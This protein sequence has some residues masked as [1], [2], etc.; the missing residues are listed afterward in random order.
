[1]TWHCLDLWAISWINYMCVTVTLCIMYRSLLFSFFLFPKFISF[2]N[3]WRW[4]SHWHST[5]FK[6]FHSDLARMIKSLLKQPGPSESILLSPK[7][8]DSLDKF[9]YLIA[10]EGLR[11][12][13]TEN[14][15]SEIWKRHQG[16]VNGDDSWPGYQK[17]HCYPLLVRI[18]HE[19]REPYS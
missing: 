12:S 3:R 9:L 16:F 17:D 18:M 14:Y 7:R 11:F 19:S 5:F 1:M 4:A 8:G 15:D 2:W 10:K 13:V 6:E